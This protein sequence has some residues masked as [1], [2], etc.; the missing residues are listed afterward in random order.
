MTRFFGAIVYILRCADGS[1]YCGSCRKP[2]EER[3]AEHRDRVHAA[4]YTATRLPVDLVWSEHFQ[5]ITDAIAYERRIKG[6]SR[7]KK[8][9]LIAGD[10]VRLKVLS[11]SR[12][13]LPGA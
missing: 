2:V 9:A 11:K 13:N 12:S 7:A 3:L 6:W 4:S 10:W 1:Y 5:S 8:D